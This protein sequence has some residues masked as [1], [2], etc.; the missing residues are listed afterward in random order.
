MVYTVSSATD[1]LYNRT[2]V[3]GTTTA[4][5]STPPAV[6][7]FSGGG[8]GDLGDICTDTSDR[9][10]YS[11]SSSSSSSTTVTTTTSS[12][13]LGVCVACP[14]AYI[15][16][17]VAPAAVALAV[18]EFRSYYNNIIILY[19]TGRGRLET[20]LPQPRYAPTAFGVPIHKHYFLSN[21]DLLRGIF[22]SFRKYLPTQ[23]QR[24]SLGTFFL[25]LLVIY[26]H[27]TVT[28]TI[29]YSACIVK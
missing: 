23:R 18:G 9:V 1:A 25:R 6:T 10:F 21:L 3:P 28:Y 13:S 2:Y 24:P 22:F 12:T 19:I 27:Y 4:G 14:C 5:H 11:T 7:G 16:L 17:T 15:L 29:I 8:G 26:T 20:S